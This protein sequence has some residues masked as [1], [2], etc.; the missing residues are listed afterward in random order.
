MID[1]L[2]QYVAQGGVLLGVSAGSILMT[3][4]ISTSALRGKSKPIEGE[5]DYS[6]L[7]L[8]NFSF[9]PHCDDISLLLDKI[10]KYSQDHQSVVYA[11]KD[12]GGIIVNGDNIRWVGDVY[13][14]DE[15]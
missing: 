6:G 10:R 13:K 7:N 5:T 1:T 15:R 12:S 11:A 8:V 2:I 9:L 14:I 4:D 3:P